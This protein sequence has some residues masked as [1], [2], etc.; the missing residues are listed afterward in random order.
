[1]SSTP[2]VSATP[3][4]SSTPPKSKTPTKQK[5]QLKTTIPTHAATIQC[6]ICTNTRAAS[7]TRQLACG[8]CFCIQCWSSCQNGSSCPLLDCHAARVTEVY[9][10]EV[11][12]HERDPNEVAEKLI[13]VN[14]LKPRQPRLLKLE[15]R[16][17]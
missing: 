13:N 9:V 4:S 14:M 10:D 3:P 8:H 2:P 1:M 11:D 17:R 12:R 6:Q 5:G 7:E 15:E 16:E